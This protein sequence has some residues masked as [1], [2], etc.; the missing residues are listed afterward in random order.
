MSSVTCHV[1]HATY[2]MSLIPTATVTNPPPANSPT[3][4]S[5]RPHATY[6]KKNHSTSSNLYWSYYPHCLSWCL[7]Y[8]GFLMIEICG[9]SRSDSDEHEFFK[10]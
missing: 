7:P 3:M 9:K 6:I 2:H 4:H 8:A 1:L 5:R 10:Y